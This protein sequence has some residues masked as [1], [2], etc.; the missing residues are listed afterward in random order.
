MLS[1][2]SIWYA[3]LALCILGNNEFITLF[4]LLFGLIYTF[5][6]IAKHIERGD[7]R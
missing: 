3:L 5:I 2:R 6:Q 7:Y 4:I 1:R